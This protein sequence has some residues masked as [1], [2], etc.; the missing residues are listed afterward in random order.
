MCL[1]SQQTGSLTITNTRTTDS[2]LYIG[3]ISSRGSSS[4]YEKIFNVTI[5]G[6]STSGE[7]VVSV[8]VMEGDSVI[9][10]TGVETNQQYRIRWYCKDTR[11][12]QITGDVNKI[13][14]DVQ[15]NK[16]TERF[17]GRLKLNHQ[18]GSLTIMNIRTTDSGAYQL[19]ISSRNNSEKTLHFT[20]S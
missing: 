19:K 3:K 14:T 2:G 17:R 8:F 9:F 10:Q 13:C 16:G 5:H 1:V 18:T 15:C 12:A 20:I 7:G 4:F 11:I 6:F